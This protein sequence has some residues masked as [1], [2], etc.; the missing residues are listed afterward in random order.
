MEKN[1]YQIL[2]AWHELVKSGAIT[3]E[4][5]LE[6][7]NEILGKAKIEEFVV[8][9]E[10]TPA[11]NIVEEAFETTEPVLTEQEYIEKYNETFNSSDA[12]EVSKPLYW[13]FGIFIFIV[14]A[15]L[16]WK[17]FLDNP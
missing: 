9:S 10:S 4:E 13:I 8:L 15:L 6:K 2:Q 12:G 11:N 17:M 7:K 3:A 1:A 14:I 16:I 5:F